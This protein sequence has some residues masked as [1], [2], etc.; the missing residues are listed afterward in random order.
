MSNSSRLKVHLIDHWCHLG[1]ARS[2]TELHGLLDTVR[3]QAPTFERDS[4]RIL[5]KALA[6]MTPLAPSPAD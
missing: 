3:M 1:T 6:R 2:E 5:L 4:Y